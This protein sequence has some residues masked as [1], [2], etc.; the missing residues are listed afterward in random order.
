MRIV[1]IHRYFAPDTPPYAHI[2][3]DV[4]VAL[5]ERGHHVTVLT[6]QPSYGDGLGSA[7]PREQLAPTVLVRRFSV[8]PDRRSSWR[9]V[10]NLVWFCVRLLASIRSIG[11]ADV[12]M[13]AS[14]PP[15]A[16]ARVGSVMARRAG[17][18]FVY[19]KQDIYP[20]VVTAPGIMRSR[21]LAVL[22]RTVDGAT[23][24]RADRVVVLS[25][26]MA[27]T[28][29]GRGVSPDRTAVINN[30]DPWEIGGREARPHD[31]NS[32]CTRPHLPRIVFAGNL[33]RFQNLETV[34]AA[35]VQV[36]PDAPVELHFFGSGALSLSMQQQVEDARLEWIHFHGHRPPDEVGRF[37]RESAAAGIVSLAPGVIR[38]AYPSKTMSYLRA[39]CPVIAMVEADSDLAKTIVEARAG[40]VVSPTDP[41]ELAQ[42]LMVVA[43]DSARLEAVRAGAASLYSGQFSRERQLA[44]WIDLFEDLGGYLHSARP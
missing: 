15:V 16:V 44:R 17:A 43:A 40:F 31:D 37:L 24:R 28:V 9:K 38:S 19:H 10:V 41:S 27:A 34:M 4:A 23:D 39:G 6:C 20:E 8:L 21:L 5:G 33:G 42:L 25:G 12:V 18:R 13:A 36:G 2:L 22:L 29:R 3:R 35:A 26:D 7:P 32:A 14:T 1:L 30:F 11:G